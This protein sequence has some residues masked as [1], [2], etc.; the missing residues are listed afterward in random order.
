M[1]L[2]KKRKLQLLEASRKAAEAQKGPRLEEN[3]VEFAADGSIQEKIYPAGC[4]IGG[5]DRRPIVMITHDES[6]FSANDE[7][8]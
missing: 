4:I 1:A 2:S 5:P 8:H 6:I 3:L 7:K